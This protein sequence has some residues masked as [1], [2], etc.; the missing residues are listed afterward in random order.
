LCYE[1]KDIKYY[2]VTF[3]GNIQNIIIDGGNS[4]QEVIEKILKSQGY[5]VENNRYYNALV[6]YKNLQEL[7][8]SKSTIYIKATLLD[9]ETGQ[10]TSYVSYYG[11]HK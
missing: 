7:Q 5:K 10:L 9:K 3:G 2:Q 1:D 8:H 11:Y 4:P 6:K